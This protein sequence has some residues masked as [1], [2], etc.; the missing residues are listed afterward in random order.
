MAANP[1]VQPMTIFFNDVQIHAV[2]NYESVIDA[3]DAAYTDLACGQAA[4]LP[5]QR[6]AAGAVKFSSMGALWTARQVAA[7]KSYPT[8]QGQFSFLINLF[9]TAANRPIAVMEA[10]EITR[11]RTAAQTAMVAARIKPTRVKKVALFGAGLQG[12]AQ[13]EALSQ[14]TAFDELA[15]VDPHMSDLPE[16]ALACRPQLGL[17]SAQEAVQNADIVITATRSQSPVLLG[18]WLKPDALVVAIGISSAGG[19]ELDT[20]SFDRASRVIVEWRPQS[21]QEAGDVLFWLKDLPHQNSK[22]IDL[23]ELYAAEWPQAEGIQIFKSV[24]TGLA[25]TAAAWLAWQRLQSAE[26]PSCA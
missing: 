22:I 14:R 19:R 18:E 5:R 2:L 26:K 17:H 21:M 1:T 4:I 10:G 13:V 16:L 15:I 3:L 8:V 24:G 7:T 6:C 9:D 23:P 25:D 11:F 12:R 20:R